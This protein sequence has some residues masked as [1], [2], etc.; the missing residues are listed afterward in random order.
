MGTFCLVW[1]V[2]MIMID[3]VV[4]MFSLIMVLAG[5]DDMTRKRFNTLVLIPFG[6]VCY[7]PDV[8]KNFIDKLEKL[9]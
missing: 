4:K 6:F 3:I 2:I 5:D 8:M 1:L 9:K 7:I